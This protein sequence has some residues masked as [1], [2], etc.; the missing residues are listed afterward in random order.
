[1]KHIRTYESYE[2]NDSKG[3]ELMDIFNSVIDDD[4]YFKSTNDIIYKS[5]ITLLDNHDEYKNWWK[6]SNFNIEE[7]I[8]YIKY[9][10][11]LEE[12][13]NKKRNLSTIYKNDAK[14]CRKTIDVLI[15]MLSTEKVYIWMIQNGQIEIYNKYPLYFKNK[16]KELDDSIELGLL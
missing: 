12:K 1:M 6:S 11:H 2:D 3:L 7:F 15:E 4:Y 10:E 16:H 14:E 8:D 5:S 9:L 13:Y